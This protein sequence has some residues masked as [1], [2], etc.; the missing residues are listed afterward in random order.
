M[1]VVEVS[2]LKHSRKK[3]LRYARTTL[4]DR[5]IPSL[6]TGLKPVHQRILWAMHGLHLKPTANYVKASRVA[7]QCFAAGTLVSTPSGPVEIQELSI[8]Q[9]VLTS[10]GNSVVTQL[11]SNE[12]SEM[13]KVSF[14]NGK[15]FVATPNQEVKI[16]IGEKFYWKEIKDLTPHDMI[17]VESET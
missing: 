13:L 4:M 14:S 7:G 11:F 2:L 16:K 8:G 3:M 5:S 9:E 17:V 10:R 6:Y 1:P 12:Q 15:E